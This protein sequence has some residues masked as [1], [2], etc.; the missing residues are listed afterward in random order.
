MGTP[1]IVANGAAFRLAVTAGVDGWRA[2]MV[3]DVEEDGD[4]MGE[5]TAT[6]WAFGRGWH[7]GDLSEQ[8]T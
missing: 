1:T 7:C 5:T 2:W 3:G 4:E 8:D 6:R